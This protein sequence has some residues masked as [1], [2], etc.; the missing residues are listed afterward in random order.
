MIIRLRH[1]ILSVILLSLCSYVPAQ[2][3]RADGY[4]GLWYRYARPSTGNSYSGGMATFSAQHNPLAIYSS[5]AKK[6]FFVYCGTQSPDTSHLQVMV[7]YFDHKTHRVP[8]PVIVFD[9][10]GVNDPHDNGTISIDSGGYIWI[11]I[12][13]RGR[14][15]PGYIFKSRMPYSI[16]SFDLMKEGEIVFPQP[17][18][19]SGSSFILMQTKVKRGR[20]LYWRTGDGTNW[21]PEQKLA[22]MGG[23]FQ[24]TNVFGKTLYSVFNYNPEGNND[25]RTNLYLVKTSDMGKTWLNVAGEVIKTPLEDVQNNALLY[26]SEKKLVYINDLNFDSEGNPVILAILSNDSGQEVGNLT[27]ELSIFQWKDKKLNINKICNVPHNQCIASIYPEKDIWKVLSPYVE[28]PKKSDSVNEIVLWTSI[29]KGSSWQKAANVTS[30]SV[31]TNSYVRRPLNASDE[32]YS[33]WSDGDPLKR[34]ECRIYFTN[35]K[36]NKVWALPYN[37]IKET[38]RPERIK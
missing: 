21:E 23:H 10:M 6:T 30:K 37:M 36:C 25:K 31:F 32:F 29:D 26:D 5:T 34:S 3:K 11:F 24:V 2:N 17:W 28:D 8:K 20:E 38:E 22:G 18:W 12:S 13:G 9:K 1:I 15:R 7:S 27:H 19:I 33:F 16:D 14:T 4:M 35:K